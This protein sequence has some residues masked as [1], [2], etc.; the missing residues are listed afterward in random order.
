[1]VPVEM[2]DKV[3]GQYVL[4]LPLENDN[5]ADFLRDPLYARATLEGLYASH[6]ELFPLQW[7][8]GWTLNG[9]ASESKKMPGLKLRKVQLKAT[10]KF[11]R[12]RPSFVM[13]YWRGHVEED[14]LAHALFLRK[15]NVP[16]W[17]LSH[18]FGR[19]A[20]YYYRAEQSLARHN[21]VGTTVKSHEAMPQ[22]LLADEQ[23]LTRRGEKGYAATTV[24]GGCILG[25]EVVDSPS[26]EALTEAYGVFQAEAEAAFPGY[27]PD[28]V[29]TDGWP[30][31]QAAWK[32]LYPLI[33]VIECILHAF[34][35]IRDRATK[36]LQEVFSNI[37]TQFWD[38]YH[39]PD[40]RTFS[41]R[42]RRLR[43]WAEDQPLS[44][45]IQNLH[46]LTQKANKWRKHFD[47][48]SAY[49]TSNA[50]D[51]LMKFMTRRSYDQQRFQGKTFQSV[52]NNYR[53]F[54]LIYNFAPLCPQARRPGETNPIPFARLNGKVY[55]HNWLQNLLTA[56]SLG[57]NH[58]HP[59]TE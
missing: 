37:Q 25:V 16:F 53:A 51:R 42:L 20:S 23:H 24:G 11:Y 56:T 54:A 19:S 1:M 5:Y 33:A 57:G 3:R 43:E 59:K 44:P 36:K 47:H 6:P 21:L 8:A 30:A 10:G 50:L 18:V 41:Q 28:T 17:A 27:A 45:M 26:E 49:R 46:K 12:I 38:L 7:E 58:H 13:D 29:N 48:P 22:D 14:N 9:S 32:V 39:A 15:F 52:T 31:T 2:Q 4:T 35:K 55:H 40:R 34:L